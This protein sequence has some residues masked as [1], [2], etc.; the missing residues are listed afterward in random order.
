MPPRRRAE[1]AEW[2]RVVDAVAHQRAPRVRLELVAV[3]PE[4][5]GAAH[6]AVDEQPARLPGLDAREPADRQPVQYEPVGDERPR[7]HRDRARSEDGEAQPRRRDRLE[8]AR[9]REEVEAVRQ[10][11]G[12]YLLA[13]EAVRSHAASAVSRSASATGSPAS[14]T[15]PA[16][17]GRSS[18]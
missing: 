8:C 13:L 7:A 11:A 14:R 6:L 4:A 17:S 10:R 16:T 18:R 2:E 3:V 9:L 15:S 12:D 1:R 5:V